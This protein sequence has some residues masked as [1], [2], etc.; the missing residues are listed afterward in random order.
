MIGLAALVPGAVVTMNVYA[1]QHAGVPD[2]RPAAADA[3]AWA[4][5]ELAAYEIPNIPN[6]AEAYFAPDNHHIIAQ[7]QDPLADR[8]EGSTSAA[9]TWI[10]TKDGESM[11]R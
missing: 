11:W 3:P 5:N 1:G 10:F 2:F 6:A 7:T 9:L 8:S 4:Q